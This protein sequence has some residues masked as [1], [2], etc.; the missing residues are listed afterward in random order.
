ME[1][2]Y[3]PK[4]LEEALEILKDMKPKIIAGGTDVMLEKKEYEG[5]MFID[6]IPCLKKIER[7][8]EILKIGAGISI[9]ELLKIKE[10]DFLREVV[11]S[12]ASP[13]IR[14]WATVGG[15]I[16]NASP[17]GDLLPVI[18]ALDGRVIAAEKGRR[19]SVAIEEFILDRKKTDLRSGEL[20]E[21]LEIQMPQK[22]D[23]QYWLKAAGRDANAL[24]KVSVFALFRV[25]KGILKEFR[26]AIGGMAPRVIRSKRL[27][28]H[29]LDRY[30]RGSANREIKKIFLE[31]RGLMSPIDD[32]RSTSRYKMKIAE[33]IY[34]EIIDKLMDCK[35]EDG[36]E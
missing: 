3:Y 13:G 24:A 34:G 18:Y 7:E 26:L 1:K 32:Q 4:T 15:N 12:I 11:K 28:K 30:N 10:T 21:G 31:Y 27:E 20:V 2:A 36:I 22:G 29:I 35:L 5:V 9:S 19:R 33:K 16:C 25:E 23:K 14:N 6:R 17:I 8:E